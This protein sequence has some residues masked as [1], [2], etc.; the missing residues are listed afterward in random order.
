MAQSSATLIAEAIAD[1]VGKPFGWCKVDANG[2]K[3]SCRV[4]VIQGR[5]IG[6]FRAHYRVV[7]WVDG[8]K[9]SRDEADSVLVGEPAQR[10]A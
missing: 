9:V 6:G 8:R 5:G 3:V 2:H 1:R 4:Q 7:F 10:A